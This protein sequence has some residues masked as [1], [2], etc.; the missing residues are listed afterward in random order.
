[1]PA[2]ALGGG[3]HFMVQTEL[4]SKGESHSTEVQGCLGAAQIGD[5]SVRAGRK[6]VLP[7]SSH[8]ACHY[9][10]L[11]AL[12]WVPRADEVLDGVF[13]PIMSLACRFTCCGS[14]PLIQFMC[15]HANRVKLLLVRRQ[16]QDSEGDGRRPI[17]RME[18]AGVVRQHV[19]SPPSTVVICDVNAFAAGHKFDYLW[20]GPRYVLRIIG[21]TPGRPQLRRGNDV[22]P[23]CLPSPKVI[24]AAFPVDAVV[25]H[26]TKG[27]SDQDAE[28]VHMVLEVELVAE[29]AALVVTPM[30]LI[31]ITIRS[32]KIRRG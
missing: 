8:V 17:R 29:L 31:D 13:K 4:S 15:E 23:V 30:P 2:D 10:V 14:I 3:D 1:L 20:A 6:P 11:R 24:P 18:L 32:E 5:L 22:L 19:P 26:A 9:M 25:T 21:N 12:L 16:A 7:T 28:V 27:L